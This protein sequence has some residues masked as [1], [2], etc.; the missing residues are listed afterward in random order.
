MEKS[1]PCAEETLNLFDTSCSN[2]LT[3][4]REHGIRSEDQAV[5]ERK[6]G[7]AER[8]THFV[9]GVRALSNGFSGFQIGPSR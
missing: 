2:R 8:C 6:V 5:I 1:R 9:K 3:P 7:T 4:L